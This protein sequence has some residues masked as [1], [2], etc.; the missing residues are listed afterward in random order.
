MRRAHGAAGLA[1]GVD[2]IA[3]VDPAGGVLDRENLLAVVADNSMLSPKYATAEPA[4]CRASRPVSKRMLRV[5]K[6]PLSMTASA[7]VISWFSTNPPLG[8]AEP[9]EPVRFPKGI[10]GRSSIEVPGPAR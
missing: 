1:L 4:A 7:V 8:L 2:D 5:P 9:F 6:E 3:A 10:S